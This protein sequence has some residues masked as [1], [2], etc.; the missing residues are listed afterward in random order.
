M[1]SNPTPT[2]DQ[3]RAPAPAPVQA[4]SVDNEEIARFAAI[5]REWW[6]EAGKFKPLHKLNPAR[7]RFIRDALCRH[8]GRDPLQ[9]RPL[10]GLRILDIGC[11]GGLVCEPLTRLGATMIG[12]D[13]EV[14]T[15]EVA[16][17]HAQSMALSIDY[18]LASAD[19]LAATGEVFDAVLALEVVEHAADPDLF[20]ELLGRLTRPSGLAVVSTI[21]RTARAFALAV[22]GA[23]YVLRW[24]PRGTHDWR[25]FLKPSEVARGLRRGGLQV[26]RVEGLSYSP[27]TDRWAISNDTGVNYLVSARKAA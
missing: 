9:A 23:E 13:A 26:E 16:K 24:L 11:G 6:D 22:V 20:L 21:N 4:P 27:F 3:N 14:E 18:R 25:K 8:F 19:A 10:E 2:P 15:V 17:L 5:A 7:I 12:I 1:S